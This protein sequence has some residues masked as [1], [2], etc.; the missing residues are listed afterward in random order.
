MLLLVGEVMAMM[1]PLAM[2]VTMV[3]VVFFVWDVNDVGEDIIDDCVLDGDDLA[4]CLRLSHFVFLGAVESKVGLLLM[5]YWWWL[6]VEVHCY[7]SEVVFIVFLR[8]WYRL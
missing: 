7:I 2:V 3:A 5:W 1:M 6:W 8:R 4:G